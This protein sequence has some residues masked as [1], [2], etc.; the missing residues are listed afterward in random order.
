[1][2]T[3]AFRIEEDT[4]RRF[5]TL[6]LTRGASGNKMSAEEIPLLGRAMREVGSRKE[7]KLVL[8]RG[9]GPNFCQGRLPDPAG[10]AP[11]TAL[12]IRSRITQPILDVYADIRATPV[13]VIAMVQGEAKGF[14]C[15]LV[16]QCDLAIAA[17]DASFSLPEMDHHLPPTLAMS[18]MLHKVPPKRMLHLVYTR[19]SIGAAE[20]L[21]LGL[22][23][24]V[25]PRA[26]LDAA[27]EKTLSR[28]LDRNRAAL[29]GVKE[30][31][32]AA[33]YTDPSGAARLAA[34]LL[35]CVLS[36]PREE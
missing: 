12:D 32:G 11:T 4:S 26:A 16:A 34:N 28:L 19:S 7:F 30:Y 13:P 25:A 18:A 15:A 1:M 23:S 35:A 27:V 6:R 9:D 8:V 33:L 5:A 22:L 29:C 2:E 20:A 17:D 24:E 14:G 36:S 31:M 3:D 21:A 10:K